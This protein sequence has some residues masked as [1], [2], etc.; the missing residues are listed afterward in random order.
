MKLLSN[1]ISDGLLI[2]FSWGPGG[3]LPDPKIT[4]SLSFLSFYTVSY[5][6]I[7]SKVSII[8]NPKQFN[9]SVKKCSDFDPPFRKSG[10]VPACYCCEVWSDD[11]RH[12]TP[13]YTITI[14]F[15]TLIDF[16]YYV[17]NY[18]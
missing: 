5:V 11:I 15:R 16:L 6:A 2:E 4:L 3:K 7:S 8:E 1:L 14:K 18:N 17:V 12:L 10:S 9:S 13:A